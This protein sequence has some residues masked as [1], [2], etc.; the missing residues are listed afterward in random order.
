MTT[1]KPK[2]AEV[3]RQ[4]K[5][6]MSKAVEIAWKSIRLRLSRSMLVTSAIVLALA[7]LCSIMTTETLTDGMRTWTQAW[8]QSEEYQ[9]L[10][11]RRDELDAQVRAL[12]GQIRQA[13]VTAPKPAKDAAAFNPKKSFGDDWDGIKEKVG[14]LPIPA[15][16]LTKL[17]TVEPEMVKTVQLF[18]DLSLQ[19]RDVRSELN[20]PEDI[21]A[22]MAG[23]G[24]PTEP[25]EIEGNKIQTR[26]IIGLALLVAFVGILNAMLMSV[27]ERF[28]EIGTM[29][30]L[31]ALDGFI[32]K[33]FLLESLFQGTV[34]TIVG[35][36]LGLLVSFGIA[37][38][39]YG[40]AAFYNVLWGQIG[41]AVV[42]SLVV[43]ML[44]SVGGAIL[45]ALQAAR[46]EP[47]AAM[48]VEA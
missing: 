38:L 37:A 46:M 19:R 26:W 18:V 4:I 21:K 7:F 6:P 36:L 3:K 11:T 32:V 43:G 22:A 48:R 44:L 28:R 12:E 27:T 9:K 23:K 30:C 1:P 8:P 35:I 45:P 33:L 2:P 17:L 40:G 39:S 14:T 42:V 25:K 15:G 20:R 13:A 47:I 24:V 29:K 31:G 16:D 5:L 10:K 34:G 41:F